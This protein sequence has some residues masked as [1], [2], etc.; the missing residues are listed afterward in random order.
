MPNVTFDELDSSRL[1]SWLNLE[2]ND[3]KHHELTQYKLGRGLFSI[4]I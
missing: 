4:T 2:D 3:E 1:Y